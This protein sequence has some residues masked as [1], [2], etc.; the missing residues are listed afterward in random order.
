MLTILAFR[1]QKPSTKNAIAVTVSAEYFDVSCLFMDSLNRNYPD[2]PDIVVCYQ[3]FTSRHINHLT[4]SSSRIRFLDIDE[5][6]IS[7]GPGMRHR[8]ELFNLKVFYPRQVIWTDLFDD[9]EVV[10]YLDSDLLV[11]SPLDHLFETTSVKIFAEAYQ[12]ADQVL[13]SSRLHQWLPLLEED[14]IADRAGQSAANAGVMAIS[15]RYRTPA[16]FQRLV[17]IQERYGPYLAWGDQSMFNIWM[18]FNG[19]EPEHDFRH[20]FQVRLLK[21]GREAEAYRDA[22]ILHLNG[23]GAT[24][25]LPHAM[26]MASVLLSSGATGRRLF[27]TYDRMLRNRTFQKVALRGWT[28]LFGRMFWHFKDY[29]PKAFSE[30]P[31]KAGHAR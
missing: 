12:G 2:H 1:S 31:V 17:M 7:E 6:A 25:L 27:A 28:D 22:C 9:Y 18:W 24:G 29:D 11:L 5:F 8:D 4:K 21:Q 30:V 3:G 19:L 16:Q 14:G 13:Y 23:W 10:L 15:R 20:N 26:Q